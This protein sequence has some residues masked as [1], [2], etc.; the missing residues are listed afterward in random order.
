MKEKELEFNIEE[1]RSA[2]RSGSASGSDQGTTVI[3]ANIETKTP[4][5]DLDK[6]IEHSQ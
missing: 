3:P 6:G 5:P 4:S 2:V 1:M